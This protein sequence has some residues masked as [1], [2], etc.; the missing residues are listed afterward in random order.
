MELTAEDTKK[1]RDRVPGVYRCL[2][3]VAEFLSDKV[4]RD[5]AAPGGWDVDPR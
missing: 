4:V 3:Q 1:R 2:H 5:V